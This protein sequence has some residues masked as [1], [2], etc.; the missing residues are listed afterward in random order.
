M[1]LSMALTALMAAYVAQFVFR[2]DD[3]V[4]T[5]RMKKA[6]ATVIHHNAILRTRTVD[7]DTR[8]LQAV[9]KAGLLDWDDCTD[10]SQYLQSDGQRSIQFGEVLSR[11]AISETY[12]VWT[13]HHSIY[14]GFSVEL[15]LDGIAT[16]HAGGNLPTR[17]P[18]KNFVTHTQHLDQAKCRSFL[19]V[20]APEQKFTPISAGGQAKLTSTS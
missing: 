3:L 9:L 10:L 11:L 14:D 5:G 18:F 13:A 7:R 16:L 19:K 2:L 20:S 12:M 17:T 4:D 8:T 15:L 1:V 6:W